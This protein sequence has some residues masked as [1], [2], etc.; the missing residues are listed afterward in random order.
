MGLLAALGWN[1]RGVKSHLNGVWWV[2]MIVET[3]HNQLYKR[4]VSRCSTHPTRYVKTQP[5]F[6]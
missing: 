2:E 5:A 3:Y 4:W 6:R 1:F